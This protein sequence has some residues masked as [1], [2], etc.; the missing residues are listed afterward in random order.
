MCAI[1]P[2]LIRSTIFVAHYLMLDLDVRIK[3]LPVVWVCL[4]GMPL[5]PQFKFLCFFYN[6]YAICIC[7][8]LIQRICHNNLIIYSGVKH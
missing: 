6:P 1:W 7:P 5:V 4:Y 2:E 8:F 3:L